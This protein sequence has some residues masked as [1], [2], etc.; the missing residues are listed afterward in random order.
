M[1]FNYRIVHNFNNDSDELKVIIGNYH[2]GEIFNMNEM[3]EN[4]KDGSI[5]KIIKM[6][7]N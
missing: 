3:V 6:K 1:G 7:T 4:L 2:N 5:G